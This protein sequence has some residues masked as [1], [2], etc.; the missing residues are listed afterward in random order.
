TNGIGMKLVVIPPG[1]FSMG[2]SDEQ[3]EGAAKVAEQLNAGGPVVSL[4]RNAERPQHRVVITR[5]FAMGA[6]EVT[7]GQYKKFAA[8]TGYQTDAEKA[9]LAGGKPAPTYINLA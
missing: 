7:V 9:N 8:A 4:I 3:A 1:E 6:T 5:P 2:S